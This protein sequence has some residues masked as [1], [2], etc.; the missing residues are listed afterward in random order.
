MSIQYFRCDD[1]EKIFNEPRTVY[2]KE[3]DEYWG[4]KQF[5]TSSV[6][7]CPKCGCEEYSNYT[8]P[9]DLEEEA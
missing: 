7:V 3:Y 1:C 9:E 2:V 8:Y 6:K 5:Y 4:A